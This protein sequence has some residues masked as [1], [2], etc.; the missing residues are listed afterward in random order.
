MLDVRQTIKYVIDGAQH[1]QINDGAIELFAKQITKRDLSKTEVVNSLSLYD[2]DLCQFIPLIFIFNTINYCFWSDK[3]KPKWLV[4]IKGKLYDGSTAL[5]FALEEEIKKNPEF[6]NGDYLARINTADLERILKGNIAI[7]L[8]KERLACLHE[9]GNV[10]LDKY[11]GSWLNL[12]DKTNRDAIKM[13]ELLVNDFHK[14]NDV[15]LF[16]GREIAF[17]KRAQLNSKMINDVLVAKGEAQLNNISKLTMFADYKIPQI[18]RKLKV[19]QYSDQLSRKIE[20]YKRIIKHS[21][22]EVEIRAATVWAGEKIVEKLQ[23]KFN[24]ITAAHLD[25]LLWNISQELGK[26]DVPYHRTLTNAY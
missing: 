8:F 6:L 26:N 5:F 17:Y 22:E 2:W 18:L 10:L 1:V 7:P 21:S 23:N 9:A 12:F 20:S 14:F 19:L 13:A 15:A 24:I 25:N 3:N 11:D 16:A 4:K